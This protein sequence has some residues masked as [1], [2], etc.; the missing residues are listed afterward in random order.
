MGFWGKLGR[1]ALRVAPYAAAPFTAG[2]S[3][4]FVN[5]ANQLADKWAESS[6]RKDAEKRGIA[7]S[8]DA[9]DRYSSMAGNAASTAGGMGAFGSGKFNAQNFQ[10]GQQQGYGGGGPYRTPDF[11]PNA[12]GIGPSSGGWQNI[13][14]MILSRNSGGGGGG[15]Q[16]AG[17]QAP[18]PSQSPAMGS[19]GYNPYDTSPNLGYAIEAGRSDAMRNQPWRQAPVATDPAMQ[20]PN[21]YPQYNPSQQNMGIGPSRAQPRY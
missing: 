9:F 15:V 17:R 16:Q 11:N 21:I 20:L 8:L 12:G 5:T 3:L 2:S 13:I 6:A 1:T 14:N 10:G 19:Q 18:M 7:P 4:A